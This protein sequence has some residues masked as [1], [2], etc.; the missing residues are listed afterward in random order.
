M[1]TSWCLYC[2]PPEMTIFAVCPDQCVLN[3][4]ISLLGG[5]VLAPQC[6]F[7]QVLLPR[8]H[9]RPLNLPLVGALGPFCPMHLGP[10]T[11]PSVP[12]DASFWFYEILS[13]SYLCGLLKVVY[14]GEGNGGSCHGGRSGA[15]SIGM[16]K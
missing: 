4:V 11:N 10:Q 13:G 2:P 14:V 5:T 9:R 1:E 12:S 3:D 8:S 7:F 16:D 6:V 15:G